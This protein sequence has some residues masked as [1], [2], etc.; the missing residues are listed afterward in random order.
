MTLFHR[1]GLDTWYNQPDN[2]PQPTKM[3]S[4]KIQASPAP[5][6]AHSLAGLIIAGT[7]AYQ[8]ILI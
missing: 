3:I 2:P 8:D 4:S 1:Q 7:K 5:G 6:Q